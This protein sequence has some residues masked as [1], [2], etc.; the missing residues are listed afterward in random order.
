MELKNRFG[1]FFI[2]VGVVLLLLFVAADIVEVEELNG[3][4]LVA[5]V[6]SLAFGLYLSIMGRTPPEESTRFRTLRRIAGR[7]KKSDGGGDEDGEQP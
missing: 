6:A 3:W 1:S 5:G 2:W 7:R 4:Y